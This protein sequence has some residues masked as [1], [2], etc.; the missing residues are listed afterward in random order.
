MAVGSFWCHPLAV[1]SPQPPS[2]FWLWSVPLG[3]LLAESY[4][5]LAAKAKLLRAEQSEWLRQDAVSDC[6]QALGPF[7]GMEQQRFMAVLSEVGAW[8]RGDAD[9]RTRHLPQPQGP[10]KQL[11]CPGHGPPDPCGHVAVGPRSDSG[12]CP[13]RTQGWGSG[14]STKRRC[15]CMGLEAGPGRVMDNQ[16]DDSAKLNHSRALLT[17][18]SQPISIAL[19]GRP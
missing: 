9:Q 19:A 15:G 18:V 11:E 7:E 1:S 3:V 14:R 17:K 8:A 16:P 4:S 2:W 10:P 13:M 6:L 5:E 12:C